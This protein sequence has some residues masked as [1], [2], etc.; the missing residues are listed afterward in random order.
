MVK[1]GSERI[2][3]PDNQ[4]QEPNNKRQEPN[5]KRQEPNKIQIRNSNSCLLSA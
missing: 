2:Q 5:N 4:K 1:N 3:E